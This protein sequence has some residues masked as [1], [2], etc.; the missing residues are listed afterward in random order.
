[1]ELPPQLQAQIADGRAVLFLGAG[2]SLGAMDAKKNHPPSGTQLAEKL[3]DKFL[4]GKFRT[5]PLN[6]V[7][8]YAISESDL[9]T[10]QGYIKEIFEPFEPT[11][12]HL[13]LPTFRWAGL[14]TTNYDLL[15]EKAYA[16]AGHPLQNVQ[17][18]IEN[19]DRVDDRMRDQ[20]S[21]MYLKL[22]GCITRLQNPNCPLILSTDQY[23]DHRS[24]RSR[25]FEHLRDWGYERTFVFVGHGLQDPDIRA[26]L[27]ELTALHERRPRYYIVA[28]QKHEIEM[29]FWESRRVT[30][31]SATFGE[32]MSAIDDAVKGTTRTLGLAVA[33]SQ[34][35][36]SEK[37]A[38]AGV[39]LSRNCLQFL[40]NE[41]DYVK[42]IT[43][44]ETVA[45][46]E[47]YRGYSRG[48]SHIEQNLDVRRTLGD[49]I[50]SDFVLADE[51][52]HAPEMDFVLIKAHAG[53]GKSVLLQRIAW[54]AA[55]DYGKLTLFLKPEGIVNTAAIDEIAD[56]CKDRIFLFVDDVGDRIR[57]L[58]SLARAV[59]L[60]K[61]KLTV[62]AAE[63][64]NEWN[65]LGSS[66]GSLVTSDNLL[67]YLSESE[68]T[69]LIEVLDKHKA[70]GTLKGKPVEQQRKAFHSRAG[71]QLLVALHEATL[72]R[73]F[74]DIIE[75]E[76][77]HVVPSEA[78]RIYLTI[79]VLNRLNIAVRAGVVSRLHGVHLSDFKER[80]FKPLEHVV[81]TVLDPGTR[82]M[83]YI[84]RHP[85]IAEIVF[86][87]ILRNQEDRFDVYLR[88]LKTLNI[89]YASDRKAFR[90]MTK[91]RTLLDLFPDTE[92]AKQI[93]KAA[94][95]I[96]GD[97]PVLIHQKGLYYMHRD[98]FRAA[99]DLF[100]RALQLWPNN[101]SFQHSRSELLLR[102][103]ENARTQLERETLLREATSIAKEIRDTKLPE[104]YAHHTLIKIGLSQL[105][106]LLAA[107]SSEQNETDIA[108][109]VRN[110]QRDLLC[111]QWAEHITAQSL[112]LRQATA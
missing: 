4:G 33:Q 80:F 85:V 28:P 3:A 7:A 81:H 40:E 97:D 8:E 69:R 55:H 12:A 73:P 39:A 27:G 9:G 61:S 18:F 98:D 89:D 2:A 19:G 48:W 65:V 5:Y 1:M 20:R 58:Q 74:E 62:I 51:S 36:I 32:F 70:L 43:S 109:V 76:Y 49:S 38:V 90:A 77:R 16:Q 46:T 24:G 41:V 59:A 45:A 50:L 37:F 35:R 87:R 82:D 63:R 13:L 112:A 99:S 72:G 6:Q 107:D 26:I 44:T 91:G 21:L 64:V 102:M 52:E 92:L 110:V 84:A 101:R 15:V 88:V 56:V 54:D 75:D 111:T 86:E 60:S 78:Q 93:I 100:N 95:G 29:R 11:S 42:G 23:V 31:I 96:A 10:V 25:L 22:H 67:R 47:F 53:A 17:P 83:T 14:A 66:A 57:E 106:T 79:C 94:E 104:A 103:S 71:R 68:T 105:R 30:P 108:N 34:H